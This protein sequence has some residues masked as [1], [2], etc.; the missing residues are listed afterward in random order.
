MKYKPHNYQAY[1]IERI[2]N[3]PAVGLFLRPGLGKTSITL[4]AINVL[5][6][7]RW[8]IAKALVV[9]PKKVAEGTWSKEAN[10]WDHLKHLRVVTVLGSSAKRIKALN[11]P[12][13]VYVINRENIPW[14]VEYYR[15][16]WP[17][18]MVVLD[19][20]T[21]FK[22]GQSKRF[23]ALKLVRRFM[24]KVVLLT[25]TPSSKGIEDL[26]AQIY[27]LDEGA[28]LGKT[29]TQYRQMYFD[30]NTHGGHFT[31][32]KAKAGA[33]D[34]VLKAISDIC[35]SMKAED[36]LDL[37]ECIDHVIPVVLD[38]KTKK[39][40]DQFER[41][42]LLEVD[43][44]VITANTAGVLTGKL[45][46]FCSG[47][48]YD[49]DKNVVHLHDCKLEAY[50]ELLERIAGEPCITFY[51]FQHD[52]DR[53]LA[54]LK[55]TKLRVR[56]YKGTKDEDDWNAGSIDVLLVHPSSCAYG[57][58]L[59]AGGRHIVWFTPNWSFELNDQGKCRLW[60][61]GS[62]Y[63]KVYVHYLVVQGCVDEDVLAAV[64]DRESTH[65]NLMCVLKARIKKVKAAMG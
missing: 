55:K 14:L 57:L 7:F 59:Q 39:T 19:E 26:W 13:D 61:Q 2:V 1:C 28:R 10:K 9:A 5:K 21:S 40:Y 4:S 53:I 24:R 64:Q 6:Y 46:Q 27:L 16:A 11:T 58:N 8:S 43:E 18:D 37:P 41:N 36:Y 29:I 15:Q 3:D 32:Y 51:G 45:L 30:C 62:P 56:V 35:I 25:G 23:K 33:A 54:A 60:R 52:K 65:E 17:F 42:L 22:N 50:M 47:A 34:T 48:M 49:N 63:D 31:E 38:N 20:S 44:D 12:A